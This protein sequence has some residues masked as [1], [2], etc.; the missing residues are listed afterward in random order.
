[1]KSRT[2]ECYKSWGRVALLV[3]YFLIVCVREATGLPPRADSENGPYRGRLSVCSE[4]ELRGDRTDDRSSFPLSTGSPL[5]N[6]G[7]LP[8][9]PA[10]PCVIFAAGE[11]LHRRVS[12]LFRGRRR[13]RPDRVCSCGSVRKA[14]GERVCFGA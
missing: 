14:A 1:M 5:K 11:P 8:M 2:A 10:F 9:E 6:S 7:R 13:R 4:P 12:R 3:A